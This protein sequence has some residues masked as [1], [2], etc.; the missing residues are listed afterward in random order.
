M[1]LGRRKDFGNQQI[2][3]IVLMDCFDD[4]LEA[5]RRNLA[6]AFIVDALSCALHSD[7]HATKN[8]TGAFTSF[9]VGSAVHGELLAKPRNLQA[10]EAGAGLGKEP[11]AA[12][13]EGM[14]AI[15]GE[16]RWSSSFLPGVC[17]KPLNLPRSQLSDSIPERPL[18]L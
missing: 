17:L 5:Q 6:A 18:S 3:Q 14:R 10:E 13:I 2:Q 7:D 4:V 12:R 8:V 11:F 16:A 15:A 1:R 9:A